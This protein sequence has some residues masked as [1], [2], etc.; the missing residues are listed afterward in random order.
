MSSTECSCRNK[1]QVAEGAETLVQEATSLLRPHFRWQQ[2]HRHPVDY[3]RG[4][5]SDVEHKNGWQLAEHVGYPHPRGIQ[6]V[7]DR[8]SWDHQ[9]APEDSKWETRRESWW[10][11]RPGS[12][13]RGSTLLE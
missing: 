1:F 8:Y 3:L 10:W 7:L 13:N 6:R 4:L 9:A 2:A 5:I 11:T 12:S